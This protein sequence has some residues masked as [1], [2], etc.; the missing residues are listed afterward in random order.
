M[1]RVM[2]GL[3]KYVLFI[4]LSVPPNRGATQPIM[5][6]NGGGPSRLQSARLV[7]A[8]AEL[9]SFG[10]CIEPMNAFVTIDLSM[11]PQPKHIAQMKSAARALTDDLRS[12][13]VTCPSDTPKR[14]CARFSVPD[15]RQADVVDR[16][17]RQFWQV[18]NY[19]DSRIGFGPTAR[20]KRRT[21]RST[22]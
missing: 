1:F 13:Q 3:R 14:I 12:V 22:E 6:S 21:R 9:G 18:E 11:E 4:T 19:N 7:A 20:A 2:V 15:A 8:V 16:I 5:A 10:V 17:G